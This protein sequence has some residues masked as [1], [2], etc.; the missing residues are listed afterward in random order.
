MLRQS[1]PVFSDIPER[2]AVLVLDQQTVGVEFQGISLRGNKIGT[3]QTL[4]N[5]K[6]LF[7]GGLGFT[8]RVF[9]THSPRFNLLAVRPGEFQGNIGRPSVPGILGPAVYIFL[10]IAEAI[11]FL[12]ATGCMSTSVGCGI[13][14]GSLIPDQDKL[15][16]VHQHRLSGPG[17]SCNE[18]I[19]VNIKGIAVAEPLDGMDASKTDATAS[20]WKPPRFLPVWPLG[21]QGA[22]KPFPTQ[23]T[24]KRNGWLAALQCAN[25][26]GHPHA[27]FG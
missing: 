15:K 19:T 20:H 9:N 3:F 23:Q 11:A 21:L 16:Q 18:E 27:R 17:A 22:A 1:L 25:A 10:C 4:G 8:A 13:V 5:D 2:F 24:A 7:L 26:R 6:E 14:P 12:V